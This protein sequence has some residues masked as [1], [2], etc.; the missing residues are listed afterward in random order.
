MNTDNT[1]SESIVP[2]DADMDQRDAAEAT[3]VADDESVEALKHKLADSERRVLL[4]HAELENFRRRT[5][6]DSEDQIRYAPLGLM[7]DV[8]QIADSLQRAIDSADSADSDS[9]GTGLLQGVKMVLQQIFTA[10]EMHGCKKIESVGQLFD[11]NVHEAVH[12]RPSDEI[13]AN[14]V[15]QEL[16]A[17]YQLHDRIVRPAQVFVSTGAS[18]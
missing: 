1:S 17:G 3:A 10:L 12:M 11:P 4:A 8:L 14:H 2:P 15:I 7:K 9:T 5:R 16:R 13:P 18:E 6:R